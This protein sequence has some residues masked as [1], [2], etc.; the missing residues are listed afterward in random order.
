[1]ILNLDW[2]EVLMRPICGNDPY[3]VSYFLF[4]KKILIYLAASGLSCGMWDLCCSMLCLSLHHVGFS[5]VV[6]H[7]LQSV[8][9]Q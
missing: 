5:L 3:A 1:M 7:G 6:A 9:A 2:C 8:R 4:F